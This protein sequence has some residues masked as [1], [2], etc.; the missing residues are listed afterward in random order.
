M[1]IYQ[2]TTAYKLTGR[3]TFFVVDR[4]KNYHIISG[5]SCLSVFPWLLFPSS[6]GL[7]ES[8]PLSFLVLTGFDIERVM[9]RA[10]TIIEGGYVSMD[11]RK[12]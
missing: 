1:K 10:A 2:S 6:L 4:F 3:Q 9:E 12:Q 8:T 5:E 7:I 11:N